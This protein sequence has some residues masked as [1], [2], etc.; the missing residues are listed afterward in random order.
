[1]LWLA[2]VLLLLGALSFCALGAS[3]AV[4]KATL[5]VGTVTQKTAALSWSVK[6]KADGYLIY[7]YDYKAKSFDRI[8]ETSKTAYTAGNLEGGES[9]LFAVRPFAKQ[10]KTLVKGKLAKVRFYTPLAAVGTIKQSETTAA[11]H[12]LQWKAVPGADSYQ[13]Y[14]F[15]DSTKTFALLGATTNPVCTVKNL[16]SAAT[17]QYKV[18]AVSLCANGKT[19]KAK[20]SAIFTAFTNPGAVLRF[21]ASDVTTTGYRLEWDA[22]AGADG[23]RVFRYNARTGKYK[24]LADVEGTSYEIENLLPCSTAFYKICAFAT[25][26][27]KVRYGEKTAVLSLTTKPETVTPYLV[28]GPAVNGLMKVGWEKGNCDGYL[29]F[30]AENEEGPYQLLEQVD[31]PDTLSCAIRSPFESET[32]YVRVKTYVTVDQTAI[33]SAYS[34]ALLIE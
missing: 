9:Y 26:L 5:T 15:K 19:V 28:A 23:Y 30:G 22:V 27:G 31:S 21:T 12:K 13:I 17:Y 11:S 24:K 18:R 10:G 29:I 20:T 25:V 7:R 2:A 34:D 6:G 8:A 1:M 16:Q 32:L 4:G 14:Y 33:L 3:G